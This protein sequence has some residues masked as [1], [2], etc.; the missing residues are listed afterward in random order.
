MFVRSAEH[1]PIFAP[2]K[3]TYVK[4]GKKRVALQRM[5]QYQYKVDAKH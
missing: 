2:C 4:G 3:A 1:V 5:I